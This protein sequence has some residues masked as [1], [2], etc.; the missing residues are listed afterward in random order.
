MSAPYLNIDC[1]LHVQ[2]DDRKKH[3][4][5]SAEVCRLK[6]ADHTFPHF[7]YPA[8]VPHKKIYIFL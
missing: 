2:A 4:R 6:C 1:S 8:A 3:N 7:V 5:T